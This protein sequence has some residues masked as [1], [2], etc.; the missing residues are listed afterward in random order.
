[1]S[2]ISVLKFGGTSVKNLARIHH[3]A[4]LIAS[5]SSDKKI[6]VVSAMGDTTDYL[7]DLAGKCSSQPNKRELDLLL[8]TGEQTSMVLLTL[9]LNAMGVRGKSLTGQQAGFLTDATFGEAQILDINWKNL[10]KALD[11]VDVLVIAGFQGATEDG[12]ITTLGRGGSDTSAVALAAA[13][14]ATVCDIYTDVDGLC[15]ADPSVVPDARVLP[16]LSYEETL[17]LAQS[18]AQVIHPRAVELAFKHGIELRIRNTFNP[19]FPGTRIRSSQSLDITEAIAGVAIKTVQS[20]ELIND[21]DNALDSGNINCD[22]AKVSIVG[23]GL[24]NEDQIQSRLVTC[25]G[26]VGVQI[27]NLTKSDLRISCFVAL[28][29]AEIACRS[30]HNEF[31][32]ASISFSERAS[33]HQTLQAGSEIANPGRKQSFDQ[34]QLSPSDLSN[35]RAQLERSMH[36]RAAG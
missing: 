29:Q 3:V 16:E 36:R 4:D 9:V 12:E 18:G 22:T 10:S 31:G 1:M 15:S 35:H 28:K 11:E 2:G 24:E 8:S 13:V 17:E 25:L 21:N 27:R 5:D 7:V 19:L 20:P 14:G 23:R 6:V 33:I 32:L 30:I 34:L 26:R